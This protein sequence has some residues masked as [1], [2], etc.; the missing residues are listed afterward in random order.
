MMNN[1]VPLENSSVAKFALTGI[2]PIILWPIMLRS[3]VTAQLV[4][5]FNAVAAHGTSEWIVLPMNVVAMACEPRRP[6][7]SLLTVG[8]LV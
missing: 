7:K 6:V 1:H 8:A 4:L 2:A 5:Q 3:H